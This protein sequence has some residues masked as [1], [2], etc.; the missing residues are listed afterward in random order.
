M[1]NRVLFVFHGWLEL[2]E[3]ERKEFDRQVRDYNSEIL[4]SRVEKSINE[5]F[6]RVHLGPVGNVCTCC[7]R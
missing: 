1:T 7:G 5:Q 6:A 3:E 2:S 4:K